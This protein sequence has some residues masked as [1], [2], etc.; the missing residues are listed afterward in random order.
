M[1]R[2]LKPV[3]DYYPKVIDVAISK[4]C[5]ISCLFCIAKQFDYAK[6]AGI[7]EPD[8][9][10]SL[11]DKLKDVFREAD[12]VHLSSNGEPLMSEVFW[13]FIDGKR[14]S[15]GIEFNTNGT[16]LT[17]NNIKRLLQYKGNLHFAVSFNGC[18]RQTYHRLIGADGFDNLKTNV[19]HLMDA[20]SKA[21]K[22]ISVFISAAIFK[23][24]LDE[25]LQICA[26]AQEVGVKQVTVQ[27]GEFCVE[28]TKDWFS[29]REQGLRYNPALM[30]KFDSSMV[31]LEKRCRESGLDLYSKDGI[32]AYW[33]DKICSSIFDY[34][35]V[36][37]S[38]D[39]YSCCN[40]AI[41]TGNLKDYD[42]FWETWNNVKRQEMRRWLI[43][44][45]FPDECQR[46]ACSYWRTR[47]KAHP[48]GAAWR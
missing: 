43:N 11:L 7:D 44:G 28:Y 35:G 25:M 9:H 38:G 5:N 19:K 14:Q 36:Y 31:E 42:T 37:A 40:A 48:P 26:I 17:A 39:T 3:L 20:A 16:L 46:P 45:K 18:S 32:D 24:T 22:K 21:G 6:G 4:R 41:L 12:Y 33:Q 27:V 15:K 1:E 23:E 34:I 47:Q 8:I 2:E 30:E 29:A 10:T 13:E